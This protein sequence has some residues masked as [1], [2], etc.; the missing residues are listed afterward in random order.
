MLHKEKTEQNQIPYPLLFAS[1]D[2]YYFLPI[3]GYA[4]KL[5]DFIVSEIDRVFLDKLDALV[6][7][8]NILSDGIVTPEDYVSFEYFPEGAKYEG[9]KELH[10]YIYESM[11][12]TI[13]FQ[14]RDTLYWKYIRLTDILYFLFHGHTYFEYSLISALVYFRNSLYNSSIDTG[15]MTEE[16]TDILLRYH[17]FRYGKNAKNKAYFKSHLCTIRHF[18]AKGRKYQWEKRIREH[19]T[20]KT[21]IRP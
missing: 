21:K 10:L 20:N 17:V 4:V 3:M 9:W 19:K 1:Y 16:I 6:F 14:Y 8:D 18:L 7:F 13:H 5:L 11:L 2:T 15:D 12:S